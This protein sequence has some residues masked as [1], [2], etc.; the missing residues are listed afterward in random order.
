MAA[1]AF[2]RLAPEH[3]DLRLIVAGDG[4]ERTALATLTPEVRD[5]VTMLGSIPNV[6]LPPYHAASDLYVGSA[7]GGESFGMVLVEAMASG[8]PVVASRI[9]GYTEVVRDGVDGILVAP[10]D[11]GALAVALARV[12]DEPGL[13]E[14]LIAAG[15]E[16]ARTF[17][18]STVVARLEVLYLHAA[19]GGPASLP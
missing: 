1:A 19:T 16:R 11:P 8:L 10:R 3:P 14:R 17:D 7:V 4:P 6:D 9:P 2:A 18:W 5:R 13:A 12:L 15:R